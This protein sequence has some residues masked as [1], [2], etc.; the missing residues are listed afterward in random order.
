MSDGKER[1]E[2]TYFTPGSRHTFILKNTSYG[3]HVQFRIA[4]E[5]SVGSGPFSENATIFIGKIARN[6]TF[7]N[8]YHIPP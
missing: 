4:G 5:T 6:I 1:K 7:L 8:C 2:N 3:S